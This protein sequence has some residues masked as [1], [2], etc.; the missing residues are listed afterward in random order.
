MMLSLEYN[1][2]TFGAIDIEEA[3]SMGRLIIGT[4]EVETKGTKKISFSYRTAESESYEG[5]FDV[6]VVDSTPVSMVL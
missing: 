2:G 1:N 5:S 6:Q 3:I 4:V